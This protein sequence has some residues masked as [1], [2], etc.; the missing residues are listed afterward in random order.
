MC[1]RHASFVATKD[2]VF[3][4]SQKAISID[5]TTQSF[6]IRQG[7]IHGCCVEWVVK[8]EFRR[9]DYSLDNEHVVAKGWVILG[10][11]NDA[12]DPFVRLH[13][14]VGVVAQK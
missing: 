9:Q 6:A 2:I 5:D 10:Q 8:L 1:Y 12:F 3:D 11:G 7:T 14:G 13:R 4:V